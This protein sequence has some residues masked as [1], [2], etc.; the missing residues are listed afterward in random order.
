MMY[1]KRGTDFSV[2]MALLAKVPNGMIQIE[3]GKWYF[4]Y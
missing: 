3:F 1:D 2:D 4:I